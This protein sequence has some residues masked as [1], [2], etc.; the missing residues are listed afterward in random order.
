MAGVPQSASQL[1]HSRRTTSE[2]RGSNVV[3][4]QDDAVS[5]HSETGE[6]I[7]GRVELD[8]PPWGF[9]LQITELNRAIFWITIEGEP[10]KHEA[11]LWLSMHGISRERVA[12]LGRQW[13]DT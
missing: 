9:C 6:T 13:A 11:Q 10:G 5:L 7:S 8:S 3:M 2:P 4:R 1:S 12:E